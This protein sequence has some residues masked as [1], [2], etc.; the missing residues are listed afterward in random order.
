MYHWCHIKLLSGSFLS[1]IAYTR[2]VLHI[3][4]F[5]MPITTLVVKDIDAFI[6]MPKLSTH[7]V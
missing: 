3:V 7:Q 1:K 2:S 5:H 6:V 4:F